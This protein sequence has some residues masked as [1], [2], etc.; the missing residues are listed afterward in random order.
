MRNVELTIEFVGARGDGLARLEE[1]L[2]YV[3]FTVPGDR[4]L[5]RIEGRR[6]DGLTAALIEVLQPGPG[7]AMPPCAHFGTC[8]GCALQHLDDEAYTA[9]K[10]T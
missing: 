5:A 8:G 9:W 7:R 3:P 4:V 6:G 10:R 2:V 1:D